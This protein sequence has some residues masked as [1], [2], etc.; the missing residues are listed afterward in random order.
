MVT[1]VCAK[2]GAS[3]TPTLSKAHGAACQALPH[4][5]IGVGGVVVPLQNRGITVFF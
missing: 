2:D 1:R 3:D 4:G 5:G